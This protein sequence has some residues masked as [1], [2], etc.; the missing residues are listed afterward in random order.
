MSSPRSSYDVVVVGASLALVGAGALLARRGF[1]VLVLGH[2]VRPEVYP[3]E[4][5]ALRRAPL[6]TAFLECPAFRRM[7]AELALVPSVRRR[8]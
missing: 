8:V 6:G 1:R 5:L 2:G 7:V 4:G 3:W